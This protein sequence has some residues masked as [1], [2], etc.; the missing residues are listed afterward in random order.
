MA[1]ISFNSTL[2]RL[3]AYTEEKQ[4]REQATS[5][6]STLVRLEVNLARP[7]SPAAQSFNSTLVRLEVHGT[8]TG[9]KLT[10]VSIPHWFD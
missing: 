6:N 9:K 10:A 2:V 7:A 3:E 8:A 1:I 4:C 5:F